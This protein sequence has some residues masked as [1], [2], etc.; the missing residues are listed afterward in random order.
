MAGYNEDTYRRT[1]MASPT[2][3]QS[4]YLGSILS[5]VLS[6]TPHC[7][8]V[9]TPTCKM[10]YMPR[11]HACSSCNSK[12][13]CTP[14][15]A[16][17]QTCMVNSYLTTICIETSA[18]TA[19][20]TICSHCYKL[21]SNVVLQ[22]KHSKVVFEQ[23]KPTSSMSSMYT[24]MES[25]V[26]ELSSHENSIT[27]RCGMITVIGVGKGGGGGQGGHCLTFHNLFWFFLRHN[28]KYYDNSEHGKY[29]PSF[30]R[31]MH[32]CYSLTVL[33]LPPPPPPPPPPASELLP[34]PMI[35]CHGGS[36]ELVKILN[37]FRSRGMQ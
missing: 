30:A 18:L 20:S 27:S 16:L 1:Q 37:N 11:S 6:R 2:S 33:H 10:H 15:I 9:I 7:A 14:D 4:I 24:S 3:L 35:L 34:T 36:L 28:N 8:R 13:K 29:V 17:N 21:F 31:C 5:L 12:P 26:S 23:A 25:V 22:L 32:T 19:S